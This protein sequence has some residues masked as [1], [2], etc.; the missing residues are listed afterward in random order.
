MKVLR[1]A[2]EQKME[3]EVGMKNQPRCRRS[4]CHW[5]H[6]LERLKKQHLRLVVDS[7]AVCP[8]CQLHRA[9]LAEVAAGGL[10]PPLSEGRP[11]LF[12]LC[13]VQYGVEGI[14]R[15]DGAYCS[16]VV[17]VVVVDVDVDGTNRTTTP[18]VVVFSLRNAL[19]CL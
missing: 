11:L 9:G 16:V 3:V 6:C 1:A 7:S 8:D 5:Q 2:G 15:V 19:R 4:S 17:G 18:V 12:V 13:V 14:K 10:R